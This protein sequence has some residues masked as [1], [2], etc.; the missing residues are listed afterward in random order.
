[1]ENYLEIYKFLI[2]GVL[3]KKKYT[4]L[5]TAEDEF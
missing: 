4:I 1:M 3:G 2:V 5:G